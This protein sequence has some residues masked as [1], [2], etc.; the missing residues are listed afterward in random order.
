MQLVLFVFKDNLFDANQV[1]ILSQHF[2]SSPVILSNFSST[3]TTLV[4][5]RHLL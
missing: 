5:D 3:I 2:L 1:S 4:P